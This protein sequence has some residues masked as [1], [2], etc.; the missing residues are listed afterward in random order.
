MVTM[1]HLF[2]HM[3][4]KARLL[5]TILP[6]VVAGLW[7][8]A[9][10]V[11]GVM[12]TE[13][14]QTLT[15]QLSTTAD[16]VTTDLDSKIQLRSDSLAV[17]AAGI[18]P[19]MLASPSA[20]ATYLQQK[21]MARSLFPTGV[22]VANAQGIIVGEQIPVPGRLGGVITGSSYFQETMRTGRLVISEPRL[23]QAAQQP[24]VF[25]TQPLKNAAGQM[26]GVLAAAMYPS[27]SHLFGKLESIKLGKSGSFLVLAP[28]HNRIVSAT[29]QSRVMQPIPAR[30]VNPLLDRRLEQG[31]DGPGVSI[32][33]EGIETFSVSRRMKTTGWM[34][35]AGVPTQ[36]A[37]ASIAA[38]RW[39]VYLAAF[40]LSVLV[41]LALY[42]ILRRQWA[43]I[44]AASARIRRMTQGREPFAPLP[45]ERRDEMGS[46]LDDF[47]ELI[48]WRKKAEHQMEYLAHHDILTGLPNRVL[49]QD[50]F[51]HVKSQAERDGLKLALFFLDLDGFKTINDSLGHGVGDALLRQIAERLRSCVR[52][53]D[54]ICR[55]GGD[56]FLVL[57]SNVSS[58]DD[59]V[60][61]LLK[62]LESLREPVYVDGR[63]LSTSVSI[64]A[65]IY[66][67]DG[68]DFDT[69]LKK[70][71]MAMYR[72]KDAGRNTYRYFNE[73]MNDEAV[74]QLAL[75]SD[76]RHALERSEF[77]LHYQPQIDLTTGRVL[78][79]EALVRW[80]HP[81]QGLVPPGRFIP[82]AEESGLIIPLGAWVMQEAC[83][84]TA[85]WRRAGL[86]PLVMAVNLSA[87]Q[88][89][90]GDV[91]QTVTSVLEMA[92][93]P[94]QALELELTE[95]ILIH[96]SENVLATVRRLKQQG[97]RFSIDDFGTGY[98][99]LSYL[100]RFEI[101][102]L[103]ID[104]S[105]VRDLAVDADDAAIVRAIIQMARSLGLSTIAEGV[106]TDEMLSR[107]RA[108]GCDEAQG[109]YFA[110]PMPAQEFEH[111]LREQNARA[112]QAA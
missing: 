26:V 15:A 110:R 111:Y 50:R 21:Q 101:D 30:G 97:V 17:I 75:R 32:T 77:V 39:Q 68:R 14:E 81:V 90:R 109:Y 92:G 80:N 104:R 48:L 67:D 99:S 65:A 86:P 71:D 78:G 35:L 36:E 87:V 33:S 55:L 3:S 103:K 22:F 107:L 102:K 112:S 18:T 41:A 58:A 29:D 64:G 16:Y 82:A 62:L 72:A 98:S 13:L 28:Q 59:T 8:L 27:D 4:L 76:L 34:V 91:E 40:L 6:L 88:F 31:Y 49:V 47:N 51:V 95:S 74:E 83:R 9:V 54:T 10:R 11:A 66:P 53:S 93:L 42:Q 5:L 108:F 84:Q 106:E 45:V 46:L 38:V 61:V 73:Q 63:E 43:P 105:F 24:V 12:Q 57:L 44:D 20:L 96:E 37:F 1:V 100:K 19:A 7:L 94:P 23:G 70:A 69:L 89:R 2:K 85:A 79:A 60:P 52:E 25:M 56:E